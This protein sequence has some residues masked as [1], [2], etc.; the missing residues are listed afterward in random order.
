MQST[1]KE[2]LARR[3]LSEAHDLR[4]ER[5]RINK[6]LKNLTVGIIADRCDSLIGEILYLK[7]VMYE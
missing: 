6:A 7:K 3:L 1:E 5:D 2:K 4:V